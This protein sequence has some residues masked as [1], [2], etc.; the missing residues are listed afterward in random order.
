[1]RLGQAVCE[2]VQLQSDPEMK[3]YI[4]PLNEA[5]YKSAWAAVEKMKAEENV[6]GMMMRDRQLAREIIFR[7]VREPDDL[8][9][10]VFESVEEMSETLDVTDMDALID[11]YNEMISISSPSLEGISPQEFDELKKVLQTMDWNALSGR[12]WYA[13]KRFLSTIS[14]SLL[15]GNSLGLPSSSQLT[16]TRE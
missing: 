4:V 8:T 16:T 7:A 12:S 5:E 6:A 14:P 2:P 3:L 9:Q 10:K 11:E 13:A 15:Q 1:M